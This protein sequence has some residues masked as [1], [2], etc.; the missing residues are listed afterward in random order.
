MNAPLHLADM[1]FSHGH[2]IRR[3]QCE[4][5]DQ[6]CT[7]LC[8]TLANMV[9][10]ITVR[11]GD[12]LIACYKELGKRGSG[13]LLHDKLKRFLL[14]S[15]SVAMLARI[16]QQLIRTP[17]SNTDV[18]LDSVHSQGLYTLLQGTIRKGAHKSW[19]IERCPL[20]DLPRRFAELQSDGYARVGIVA[21]SES[22]WTI[23]RNAV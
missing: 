16:V 17:G 19:L 6:V 5:L 20:N 21:A 10:L 14:A 11:E 4:C 2:E 9:R 3:T 1:R 15:Q 22:N 8:S 13:F 7:I 12:Q 18:L 23:K